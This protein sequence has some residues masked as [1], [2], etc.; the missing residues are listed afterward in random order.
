MLHRET[1]PRETRFSKMRNRKW[2]R[3]FF[4]AS[5]CFPPLQKDEEEEEEEEHEKCLL[6]GGSGTT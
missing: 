4:P 5:D 3:L 6:L 2:L 1:G